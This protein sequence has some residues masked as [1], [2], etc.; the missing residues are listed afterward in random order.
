M[1]LLPRLASTFALSFSML[2]GAALA[3][4]A[5]GEVSVRSVD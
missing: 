3:A 5:S 4:S 2:A 1:T